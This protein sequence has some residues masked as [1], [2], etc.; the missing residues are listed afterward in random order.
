MSTDPTTPAAP[1]P[2]AAPVAPVAPAAPAASVPSS[3]VEQP[4]VGA[5]QP[6][7]PFD[8]QRAMAKIHETNR[9]AASLRERLK[10]AEAA[11][12]EHQDAGKS[13]VQKAIER[14]TAAEAQVAEL[15]A[16][17]LRT[18]AAVAA[19]L[20]PEAAA[21]IQGTTAEEI[22]ANA[23]AL[24]GLLAPAPQQ[25]P[26][27]PAPMSRPVARPVAGSADPTQEPLELDPA[28]LAE[29]VP[30]GALY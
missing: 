16:A 5:P 30:R 9:E 29:Q 23:T 3:T 22:T 18:Q 13:E 25:T 28:K 2:P 14:A 10:A 12:A 21:H 7:E 11:L 1:E 24:A 27:S 19:G 8:P 17:Q 4:P 20:P 15:Q 26:A 6:D